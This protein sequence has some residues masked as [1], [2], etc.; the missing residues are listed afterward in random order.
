MEFNPNEP[1]EVEDEEPEFDPNQPFEA[2]GKGPPP[3]PGLPVPIH[4]DAPAMQGVS[5]EQEAVLKTPARGSVRAVA[6]EKENWG[7]WE[8]KAFPDAPKEEVLNPEAAGL[9]QGM[10][11]EQGDEIAGA[12]GATVGMGDGDGWN[13][14]RKDLRNRLREKVKASEAA[15]PVRYGVA[16]FVGAVGSSALTPGLGAVRTGGLVTGGLKSL[17]RSALHGAAGGAV[18][19]FGASEK[20]IDEDPYGLAG[21]TVLGGTVGA[22]T[23]LTFGAPKAIYTGV[24]GKIANARPSIK[25]PPEFL[26]NPKA[27]MNAPTKATL[28]KKVADGGQ[29]IR[30]Q[31]IAHETH[32]REMSRDVIIERSDILS[33]IA[34]RKEE[35]L[36]KMGTGKGSPRQRATLKYYKQM[37]K[38]FA[39]KEKSGSATITYKPLSA[40]VLHEENKAI[41]DLVKYGMESKGSNRKVDSASVKGLAA[42]FRELLRERVGK[43]YADNMDEAAKRFGVA[44]KL[45][46]PA[47]HADDINKFSGV[48]G[49]AARRD[50]I[51]GGAR[52]VLSEADQVL[53]K[54]SGKSKYRPDFA[55]KA[56]MRGAKEELR[57]QMQSLPPRKETSLFKTAV[58]MLPASRAVKAA[59][60]M[61][62]SAPDAPKS[63]RYPSEAD[64]GMKDIDD[65]LSYLSPKD[66]QAVLQKLG[67]AS[68]KERL[69]I[70]RALGKMATSPFD[71]KNIGYQAGR[72]S[73]EE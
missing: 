36:A 34:A 62:K 54:T 14:R 16:N 38:K 46:S 68:P 29:T 40:D 70:L 19:A 61:M 43:D 13:A 66:R 73:A 64:F 39:E 41:R 57:S 6:P 52:S 4:P 65:V 72:I 51:G 2:D 26:E 3:Y 55:K 27:V 59:R 18:G 22:G 7:R 1:F 44:K 45:P 50:E 42:D 10:T 28:T 47:K 32:A 69:T 21:D 49:R 30:N 25:V 17:G 37:E 63:G 23:A 60:A 11:R 24:K 71:S 58:G 12:V 31:G 9:Y 35:V 56:Q 48:V 67:R 8:G 33:R 5:P 20:N 15:H 53:Q